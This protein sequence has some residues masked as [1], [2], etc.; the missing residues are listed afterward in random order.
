MLNRLGQGEQVFFPP[1]A[2]QR[3]GDFFFAR[4][5]PA[6]FEICQLQWVALASDDCAQN[7]LASLTDNVRNYIGQL[8]IHER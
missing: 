5:N 7:L 4:H 3:L 2:L 8:Y 1:V 6:V